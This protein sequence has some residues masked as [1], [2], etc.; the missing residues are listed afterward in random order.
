MGHH[1]TRPTAADLTDLGGAWQVRRSR[2]SLA[3]RLGRE[4]DTLEGEQ[5]LVDLG[6]GDLDVAQPLVES[7]EA[8]LETVHPGVETVHPGDKV[9]MHVVDAGM[10]VVDAGMHVVD[11]GVHAG[12]LRRQQTGEHHKGSDDPLRVAAHRRRFISWRPSPFAAA[13]RCVSAPVYHEVVMAARPFRP[14]GHFRSL[15]VVQ[16]AFKDARDRVGRHRAFDN[17]EMQTIHGPDA[18]DETIDRRRSARRTPGSPSRPAKE[19]RRPPVR[20]IGLVHNPGC[21][22]RASLRVGGGRGRGRLRRA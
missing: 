1:T 8:C 16:P 21:G 13:I 4:D 6:E 17:P 18:E 2:P 14:F 9:G 12:D 11:A 5:S 7:V 10:H 20:E 3:G 22:G 15:R 19:W